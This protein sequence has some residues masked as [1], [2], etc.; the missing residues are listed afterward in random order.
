MCTFV[1]HFIEFNMSVPKIFLLML[2]TESLKIMNG[3]RPKLTTGII[4][5]LF[6]MTFHARTV[7]LMEVKSVWQPLCRDKPNEVH[8]IRTLQHNVY[9]MR[10]KSQLNCQVGLFKVLP[11]ARKKMLF[12]AWETLTETWVTKICQH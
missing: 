10:D 3:L 8:H 1:L 7:L 2:G 12:Q 11:A 6:L 9:V 5:T 4:Y